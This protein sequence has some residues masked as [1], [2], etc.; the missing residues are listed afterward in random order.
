MSGGERENRSLSEL[1]FSNFSEEAVGAVGCLLVPVE[2][3]AGCTWPIPV[4][5]G[6]P[7]GQPEQG[8]VGGRQWSCGST[9]CL[10]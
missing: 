1:S 4:S 3:W 6:C 2:L 10:A 8:H 5:S 9:V 7:W